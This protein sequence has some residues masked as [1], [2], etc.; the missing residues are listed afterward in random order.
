MVA[1]FARATGGL[2]GVEQKRMF[3]YPASFVN[4]NMFAGL[5]GE[6]LFVRLPDVEAA[7]VRSDGGRS[8]SLARNVP[9]WDSTLTFFVSPRTPVPWTIAL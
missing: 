2:P 1:L 4:G 9:D 6:D 3:S 8:W 7:A 5:F